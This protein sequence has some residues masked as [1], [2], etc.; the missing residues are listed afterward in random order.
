MIQLFTALAIT[1]DDAHDSEKQFDLYTGTDQPTSLSVEVGCVSDS[2]SDDNQFTI[3]LWVSPDY[4]SVD[5]KADAKWI[6]AGHE[7]F[8]P[9]NILVGENY[10]V[11]AIDSSTAFAHHQLVPSQNLR[12]KLVAQRHQVAGAGTNPI[13]VNAWSNS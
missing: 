6:K 5:D 4:Y 13:T 2:A 9:V 3:H 7:L 12:G 8:R 1:D 11:G 10:G